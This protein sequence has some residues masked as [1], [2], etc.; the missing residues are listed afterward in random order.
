MSVWTRALRGLVNARPVV[1][2]LTVI[3]L[4]FEVGIVLM[5]MPWKPYWEDNYFLISQPSLLAI[6]A[7]PFVRGAVSGLGVVN[8]CAGLA[9]LW[10]LFISLGTGLPPES[11]PPGVSPSRADRH[12][13]VHAPHR[14]SDQ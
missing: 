7:N 11:D 2:Q 5:V 13:P 4:F 9:E 1:R 3:V 12:D 6:A 10:R 14:L 8:V